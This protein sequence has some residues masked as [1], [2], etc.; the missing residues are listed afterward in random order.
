MQQLQVP[1]RLVKVSLYINNIISPLLVNNGQL[2]YD[3]SKGWE[4]GNLI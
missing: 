2:V 1:H 4:L 3:E